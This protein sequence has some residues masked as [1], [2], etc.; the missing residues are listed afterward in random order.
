MSPSPIFANA[1]FTFEEM[2]ASRKIEETNTLS[3]YSAP[4][5]VL[6]SESSVGSFDGYQV[7]IRIYKHQNVSNQTPLLIWMH[8]G[9]FIGGGLDMPE[10]HFTSF[11]IA[12]RARATVVSIDYR[13]CND[14]TK[15]PTPQRDVL[16]VAQWALSAES[17]LSYASDRVYLGGASAG[18][19][20]SG[21]LA[22]MLRDRGFLMAG[23]LPIYGV[24]HFEELPPSAELAQHCEAHFGKPQSLLIGHNAWLMPDASVCAGFHPWPGEALDYSGLPP[25]F[26][27]HA[28][29]DILR[30]TGEPW[31]ASLRDVGVSVDEVVET[32]SRHGFLNDLPVENPMQNRA[33]DR[34]ATFIGS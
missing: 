7:P 33:L 20:L 26:F 12:H 6:V 4:K 10:A 13:L 21:S 34:M 22:L 16:A 15:F 28:D 27:I 24:G 14:E 19:C 8:G 5:D 29:F 1:P 31:A 25:H 2:I 23:V 11:E 3:R 30:S 18:A 17:G 9:G 32:G